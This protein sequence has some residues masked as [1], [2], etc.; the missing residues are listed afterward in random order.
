MQLSRSA[1]LSLGFIKSQGDLAHSVVAFLKVQEY[2][3]RCVVLVRHHEAFSTWYSLTVLFEASSVTVM[4]LGF[5][6][7]RVVIHPFVAMR[8]FC[9][10]PP[11]SLIILVET[12]FGRVV[13]DLQGRLA[14][15]ESHC[16]RNA[17][18][19][20][21][22]CSQVVMVFSPQ[23]PRAVVNAVSAANGTAKSKF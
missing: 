7:H 17:N 14:R 23:H 12:S 9:K 6:G 19:K 13:S 11:V 16:W 3:L 10:T 22:C 2:A 4:S 21:F 20:C 8:V 18:W 1:L 15:Q 5:T